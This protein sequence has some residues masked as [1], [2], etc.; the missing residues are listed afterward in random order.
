MLWVMVA[1]IVILV[2]LLVGLALGLYEARRG[3][4]RW[5]WLLGAIAGPFALPLARQIEQNEGLARPLDVGTGTGHGPGAVRLLVGIDGSE[6]SIDAARRAVDLLGSRLGE[7]E[8]ALVVDFD[9]QEATPGPLTADSPDL[10]TERRALEDA[11][12][13]LGRWLGFEPAT[14]I[15]TGVPADALRRRAVD[16]DFDVIAVGSRGR[17]LAKRLLGSCAST[18]AHGSETP[19]MIMPSPNRAGADGSP[20]RETSGR[21]V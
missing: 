19:T 18:L 17:G 5:L 2:W 15:L 7:L 11:A 4:W 9:V 14:V 13:R 10:A 1:V 8:L 3:H 12:E 20:V 6:E 16:G 21:E